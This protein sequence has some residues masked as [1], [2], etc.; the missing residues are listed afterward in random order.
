[1][2]AVVFLEG[3]GCCMG[4]GRAFAGGGGDAVVFLE[5]GECWMGGKEAFGVGVIFCGG[6]GVFVVVLVMVSRL[7]VRQCSD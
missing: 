1:M 4:L 5:G 2:D 3:G 7:G 6:D